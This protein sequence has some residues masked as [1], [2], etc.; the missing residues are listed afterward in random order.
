MCDIN[1]LQ[2][3]KHI[4]ITQFI[5]LFSISLYAQ[6]D[7]FQGNQITSPEINADHSVTFPLQAP[8]ALKVS[9]TGDWIPIQ[10]FRDPST[11]E[12]QLIVVMPNGNVLQEAAPGKSSDGFVAPSFM[13]PQTMDGKF[14]K[15]IIDIIKFVESNCRTTE[16][17]N[18]KRRAC[19]CGVHGRL[20]QCIHFKILSRYI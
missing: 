14:E 15:S 17:K 7:L 1:H 13:L 4:L 9:I 10:V 8:D 2:I 16:K 20:S 19:N 12:M 3:M 6:Q 5:G 18:K 11:K